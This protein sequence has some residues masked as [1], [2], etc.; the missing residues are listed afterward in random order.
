M[1]E[2]MTFSLTATPKPPRGNQPVAV[3]LEERKL[4]H[5]ENKRN[6]EKNIRNIISNTIFS[7]VG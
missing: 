6:F 2:Y 3:H 4:L 1:K 5:K 7:N